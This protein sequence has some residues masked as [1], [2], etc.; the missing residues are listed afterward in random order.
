MFNFFLLGSLRAVLSGILHSQ[1]PSY[2]CIPRLTG[3]G[4]A[5][6]SFNESA[7]FSQAGKASWV[8]KGDLGVSENRGP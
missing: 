4:G 8:Y 7:D 5:G 6:Q 2:I 1:G 3:F